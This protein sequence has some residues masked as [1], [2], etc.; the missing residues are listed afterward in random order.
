[1]SGLQTRS[2]LRTVMWEQAT[3]ISYILC[4]N[5][6]FNDIARILHIHCICVSLSHIIFLF[7]TMLINMKPCFHPLSVFFTI[8]YMYSI[9]KLLRLNCLLRFENI[10]R[11]PPSPRPLQNL[12]HLNHTPF[13]TFSINSFGKWHRKNVLNIINVICLCLSVLILF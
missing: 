12:H 4:W 10:T 7:F 13:F 1:M 2:R 5:Y 8:I 6:P 11:S 9:F 3:Y